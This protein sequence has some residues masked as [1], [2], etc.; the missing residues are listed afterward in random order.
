MTPDAPVNCGTSIFRHKKYKI[1]DNS[2][3][4]EEWTDRT[5]NQFTDTEPWEEIDRI[6]NIYN[7]L[8]LFKSHNVHGVSE[9]FGETIENSRLFQ[10]FFFDVE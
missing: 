10:L 4:R 3:F 9:Y 2:I 6:G 8:V 7:R 5:N 1:K